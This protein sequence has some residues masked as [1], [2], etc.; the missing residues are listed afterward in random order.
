MTVLLNIARLI[1]NLEQVEDPCIGDDN[2]EALVK[3]NA[4]TRQ[5][6]ETGDKDGNDN[7]ASVHDVS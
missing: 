5:S 3:D 7:S 6:D 4:A 2:K 1:R